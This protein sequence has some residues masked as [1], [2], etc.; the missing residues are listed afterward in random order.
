MLFSGRQRELPRAIAF[1]RSPAQRRLNPAS[2]STAPGP[3]AIEV[4]VW[5]MDYAAFGSFVAL[6]PSL[7]I[8]TLMLDDGRQ[9]KGFLC[10]PYAVRGAE[11]I[12]EFGG[13]RAWLGRTAVA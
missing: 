2:F 11:D 1:M 7:A 6:F 12:T 9:V 13:W 4:E 10:E 8:G 5:E 3:G